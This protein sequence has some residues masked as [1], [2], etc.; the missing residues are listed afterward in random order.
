[1]R[2]IILT[3]ILI[4]MILPAPSALAYSD[5]ADDF[6]LACRQ[7][8]T[9]FPP[10][11]WSDDDLRSAALEVLNAYEAE[12]SD[13]WAVRFCLIALGHARNPDDVGLVLNYEETMPEVV[14]QAFAGF[15]DADAV[16][17]LLRWIDS[18]EPYYREHAIRGIGEID[19]SEMDDPDGWRERLTEELREA[20]DEEE[21]DAIAEL[22]E[23]TVQELESGSAGNVH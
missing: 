1:M 18:D 11:D 16:E 21:I 17:C 3:A 8:D 22:L 2:K 4:V 7:F 15:P 23:E 14:L 9:E 20:L 19:V 10:D 6:L 12:G 5:N 13:E